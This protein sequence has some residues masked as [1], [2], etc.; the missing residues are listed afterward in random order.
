LLRRR[1]AAPLAILAVATALACATFGARETG[2]LFFW[3][4][5]SPGDMGGSAHLLG[6]VHFGRS[7]FRFDPAIQAAFEE[8]DAL[9]MELDPEDI[10][11]ERM[12]VLLDEMGRLPQ[13]ETLSDLLSPE[14][15]EA[16]TETLERRGYPAFTLDGFE[17]WVAITVLSSLEIESGGL[18]REE[19]VEAHFVEQARAGMEVIGLESP[20][21]QMSLFDDMPLDLQEDIL[22]ELLVEDGA[23]RDTTDAVVEAWLRGDTERLAEVALTG[24][25][26]DEAARAFQ[27]ALYRKRNRRMAM[28]IAELIDGG[29]RWFVV[30][31]AAHMVGDD[32]IPALLAER[33]YLVRQIEKTK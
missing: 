26:R 21:E 1:H 15:Y 17:P 6:S 31:G 28:K 20:E 9:A 2:R 7:D 5:E 11:P 23:F 32:G 14:T 8:S 3:A 10:T 4:V 33:G 12:T 16:L 13:G 30:I 29:G 22:R 19:G 27:E 25:Y 18:S 24:P